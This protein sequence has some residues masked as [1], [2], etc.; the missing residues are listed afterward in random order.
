MAGQEFQKQSGR[1]Y[2][3]R[4]YWHLFSLFFFL[5]GSV[6]SWRIWGV[7]SVGE[8]EPGFWDLFS[9]AVIALV[10]MVLVVHYFTAR[11][12]L[13]E[14]AIEQR[15]LLGRKKLRFDQIRGRREYVV[16]GEDGSTRYL[17]IEPN[18]DRLPTLNF[19]KGYAFDRVFLSWFYSLP[20]LDS[21]AKGSSFGL[22]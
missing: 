21:Q 4:W 2:R 3:L 22:V 1:V 19:V 17:K 10:G 15:N 8:H 18:D 7:G 11:I 13:F 9:S 20:D 6:A 5:F 16:S 12:I 14:D